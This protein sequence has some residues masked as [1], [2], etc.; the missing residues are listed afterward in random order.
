[1][2]ALSEPWQTIVVGGGFL[3]GLALVVTGFL[4]AVNPPYHDTRFQRTR[5]ALVCTLVVAVG[6]ALM[7]IA[8]AVADS[9]VGDLG[10]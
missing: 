5:Y 7:S 8:W 10:T 2:I 1:V 9:A 4:S 6:F 3:T